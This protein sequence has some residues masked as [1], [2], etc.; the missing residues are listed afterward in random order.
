MYTHTYIHTYM[1]IYIYIYTYVYT[2]TVA[3]V[4][5]GYGSLPSR[6]QFQKKERAAD[7]VNKY[8]C[9][10]VYIYIYIYIYII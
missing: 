8:V 5:E 9:M 2:Y 3:Q 1:H 10:Y 4:C 6:H 7:V